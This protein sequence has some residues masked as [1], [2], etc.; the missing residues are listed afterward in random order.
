MDAELLLKNIERRDFLKIISI[1]GLGGLVYPA[2]NLKGLVP[3]SLTRVVVVQDD[4]CYASNK[5]N[6]AVVSAMIDAGMKSLTGNTSAGDAWKS[7]LPGIDTTKKVAIKVNC[8]NSSLST[9]PEVAY[10]L[11]SSIS[12]MT[13]NGELFPENNV[14]IFDRTSGELRNAKYTINNTTSGVRCIGTD[15]NPGYSAQT[16]NVAG[17]TQKISKI[18]TEMSDYL[19]NAAVLKNHGGSG[20]TLCMKNH[21]GTCNSPGNL[22]GGNCD[23]SIPALNA[24]EPIK[25]KQKLFVIDAI[26]GITSGGPGGPP[27]IAPKRLIFGTDIVAVDTV[28]RKLLADNKASQLSIATHI[29]TA[30]SKYSLGTNDLNQIEIIN[31]TNPSTGIENSLAESEIIL[32]QNFPNPFDSETSI[33]FYLPKPMIVDMTIYDINGA[34]VRKMVCSK[35]QSGWSSVLW[36]GKDNLDIPLPNGYYI[37]TLSVKSYKKSIIIQILK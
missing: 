33:G 22:H 7:V 31:I 15:S 32:S 1:T 29:D 25:S 16:Y 36:N 37:C 4:N 9:H 35:F 24:L 3:A 17:S 27:K 13:F 12:K 2:G 28:G 21:Y 18:L 8:I 11:A 23:P 10:E 20:V 6:Q 30:A 34:E 26:L 14:I 19:V 5:I